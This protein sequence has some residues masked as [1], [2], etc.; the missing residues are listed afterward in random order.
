[1]EEITTSSK[2]L[3]GGQ[4]VSGTRDAS[5]TFTIYFN[6]LAQKF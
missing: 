4:K 2:D 3:K 1:M 6:I 5:L